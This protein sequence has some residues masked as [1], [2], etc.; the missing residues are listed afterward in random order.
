MDTPTAAGV[1]ETR[2]P[3]SALSG[4]PQTVLPLTPRARN[5]RS[6]LSGKRDS[7]WEP[8]LGRTPTAGVTQ[9]RDVEILAG[10]PRRP[11]CGFPARQTRHPR[12]PAACSVPAQA[13]AAGRATR[14]EASL[15]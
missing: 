9:P 12:R 10:R 14:R 7:P 3:R 15:S 2:R 5:I 11:S 4:T 6:A 13:G 8:F 1:T